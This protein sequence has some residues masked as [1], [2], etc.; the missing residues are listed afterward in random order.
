MLKRLVIPVIVLAFLI[1]LFPVPAS[2]KVHWGVYVGPS[3]PAYAY[4]YPYTPYPNYYVAPY[5]AY[6]YAPAF[7]YEYGYR[8]Y[9]GYDHHHWHRHRDDWRH[10]RDDWRHHRNEQRE[11][12]HHR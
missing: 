5:P 10:H 9:G 1:M 11:H 7:G 4:G 6:A 3:Y 2:A 8:S 12:H